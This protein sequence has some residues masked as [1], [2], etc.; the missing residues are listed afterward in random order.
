[1]ASEDCAAWSQRFTVASE[2]GDYD[3]WLSTLE[4]L[5]RILAMPSAR[6][7]F[8]SPTV[9]AADKRAAQAMGPI[10]LLVYQIRARFSGAM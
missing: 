3:L 6:V 2:Q 1:M 4:E 8:I 10:L 9:D 5:T 7:V